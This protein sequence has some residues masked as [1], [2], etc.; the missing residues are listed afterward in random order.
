M[1]GIC[2]IRGHS[3]HVRCNISA[4]FT[5]LV[6][7]YVPLS[8]IEGLQS[9]LP[10]IQLLHRPHIL[11]EVSEESMGPFH[12]LQAWGHGSARER[13][14]KDQTRLPLMISSHASGLHGNG[15]EW[16]WHLLILCGQSKGTQLT[17]SWALFS[18]LVDSLQQPLNVFIASKN[19]FKMFSYHCVC[20]HVHM[21]EHVCVCPHA[22]VYMHMWSRAI[23]GY[24]P[25]LLYTF[26]FET[27]PLSE[28][29]VH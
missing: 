1:V 7:A 9:Q 14:S 17:T 25:H 19:V 27:G 18:I 20:L 2:S 13:T 6:F 29:E 4:G 22:Y 11:V 24:L 21:H 23:A 15:P 5:H 3:E 26:L 12:P 8:Q 10:Q 16:E 28:Y